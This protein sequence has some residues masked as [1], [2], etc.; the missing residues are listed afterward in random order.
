LLIA[1]FAVQLRWLPTGGMFDFHKPE[2]PVEYILT[3]LKHMILPVS[4]LVL[5]LLFQLVF[6][7][8]T[9]FIIYSEEDYVDLARA[10]GLS[11]STLEKQYILKPALPYIITSFATSL[12]AFW[13]L[14]V[15]LE[16]VFQWPGIGLLYIKSLPNYWKESVEIGDLMIVIQI[17][18][19]FAYLLGLLVFLLDES[20]LAAGG[21]RSFGA[22]FIR[23]GEIDVFVDHAKA[24]EDQSAGVSAVPRS[25]NPEHLR[26]DE[27]ARSAN[28][29]LVILKRIAWRQPVQCR[30]LVRD[31]ASR[32]GSCSQP[33]PVWSSRPCMPP[34]PP[35]PRIMTT[36][37]SGQRST[38]AN[39]AS[40]ASGAPKAISI[41]AN[42]AAPIR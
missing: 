32:V 2:E 12:I 24:A 1:V 42:A 34:I 7:W 13:Q 31:S 20:H 28:P 36:I 4:A 29:R 6:I 27:R 15:A 17:V 30:W 8:R 10:K 25:A 35:M 21:C 11:N 16:A 23:R 22:T 14:T 19:I 9:F 3:L 37:I 38:M 40:E 26:L 33:W 39:G 5:S 18:V 41:A